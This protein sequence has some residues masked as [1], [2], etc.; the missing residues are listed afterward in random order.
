M[1]IKVFKEKVF[2]HA[3]AQG[4]SDCEIYF[5]N[6]ENFS[7]QIFKGEVKKY[8][9]SAV[10][11]LSFR[12][13]FD[14]KMGYAFTERIDDSIVEYLVNSAKENAI[15]KEETDEELYKG[16]ENYP[17]TSAYTQPTQTANEKIEM[18][19]TMEK[20][21]YDMDNRIKNVDYCSVSNGSSSTYIA[22][23]YGLDLYEVSGSA[24]AY[25]SSLAQSLEKDSEQVKTGAYLFKQKNFANFNA[26]DIAKQATDK[27]IA[28][29]GATTVR[30]GEYNIILDPK[31]AS[32]LLPIFAPIFF[33]ESVQ[34]GF[35]LLKGRIGEK[36]ASDI[37]NI[38]DDIAHANSIHEFSFD[39]EGV[40]AKNKCII[41]NGVLQNF[42][43][44]LKSAKKDGT[45]TTGN[46][47]K[48]SF[49]TAVG[50]GT[51]N[52]YIEPSDMSED[53]LLAELNEGLYITSLAGLHSGTSAISGDFSLLA[54]GFKVENGKKSAPIEQFTIAGNFYQMLKSITAVGDT[55]YFG[56]GTVG[57]PAILIEN[58]KIAGE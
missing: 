52:F 50:T 23:S 38:K 33:A 16:D 2:A 58:M 13:T 40:S 24:S 51:L 28:K 15:I 22:N 11:G 31:T 27:A 32:S 1:D 30:S 35:S 56:G 47:N 53:A 49:K 41:E 17:V 55:V 36:I 45:S 20:L 8:Q 39:S 26:F 10:M 7:V 37:L 4:F 12:G 5:T 42:L 21:A 29:L 43:Y 14:N 9:N 6:N 19:K 54:E 57:S 3:K 25:V 44:N 46:G 34:K 18:A 48:P